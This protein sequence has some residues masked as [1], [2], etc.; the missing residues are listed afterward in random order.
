M[1]YISP[2]LLLL[3]LC[4]L[5][6]FCC[7]LR[8]ATNSMNC[9]TSLAYHNLWWPSLLIIFDISEGLPQPLLTIFGELSND[10]P[11]ENSYFSKQDGL[12]FYVYIPKYFTIFWSRQRILKWKWRTICRFCSDSF[13]W[14]S[15]IIQST[16]EVFSNSSEL[17]FH[18]RFVSL[19]SLSSSPIQFQN[20]MYISPWKRDAVIQ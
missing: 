20:S 16:Q 2:H 6:S 17:H 4:S 8:A 15:M 10:K 13:I 9:F 12:R 5:F 18:N 1:S 11:P 19:F 14:S 3:V 7:T